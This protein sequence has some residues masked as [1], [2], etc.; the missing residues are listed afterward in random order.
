LKNYLYWAKISI[1]EL[2]VKGMRIY[3]PLNFILEPISDYLQN[4][5]IVKE[6]SMMLVQRVY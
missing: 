2:A 3:F 4:H 5:L 6:S 1:E